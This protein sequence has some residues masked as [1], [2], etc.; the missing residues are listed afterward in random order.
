MPSTQVSRSTLSDGIQGT[1]ETVEM[2]AKVAMGPYGAGSVKIRNLALAIVHEA[3]VSEKDQ[4]SEVIA[5]HVW[6]MRH[7]RYVRD[8]YGIELLTYPET[9]AFD[10]ANGDCDDHVILEAALLGSIG[11][12]THFV[13]IGFAPNLFSHVYLLADLKNGQIPLDPIV[14]NQPAGWQAPNPMIKK[15]YPA[16]RP[17]GLGSLSSSVA[18]SLGSILFILAIIF[19]RRRGK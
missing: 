12:A 18:T 8:P 13:V 11:I 7:L 6:V 17:E 1:D 9:L 4:L 15:I 19:G 10:N 14:K 16:N 3:G 5:I 2:M